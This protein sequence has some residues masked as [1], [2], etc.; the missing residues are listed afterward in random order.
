MCSRYKCSSSIGKAHHRHLHI[1]TLADVAATRWSGGQKG[2][3]LVL[4][5]KESASARTQTHTHTLHFYCPYIHTHTRSRR[6]TRA[7]RHTVPAWLTA[8]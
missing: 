1:Y 5:A 4:K 3:W 2:M 6:Q 8:W 7:R